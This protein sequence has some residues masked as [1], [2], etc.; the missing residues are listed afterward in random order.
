MNGGVVIKL[1]DLPPMNWKDTQLIY[2]A[3]ARKNE[4]CLILTSTKEP[5][6]CIGFAG[7]LKK[8]LDLEYCKQNDIG[9]FRRE[10]GGGTVYLDKDQLFFQ[11]ILRRD[12]P[13]TP[14]FQ[15]AFFKRFLEPVVKT[16]NS[17]GM[18]GRFV[19]LNDLI[20][21][22]KKISGN[23]GGEIGD[24]KV[25]IGNLLLDFDFETMVEILNVPNEGFRKMVFNGMQS[26]MT[27][28]KNEL[29][30]IPSQEEM[31]KSLVLEYEKLLGPM[32]RSEPED[33]VFDL[34]R[35]LEEQFSSEK[36]LFQRVPK[37]EGRDIKIRES[38][39]I[40][41]RT[42]IEKDWNVE[43]NLEL[44]EKKIMELE[45]VRASGYDVS[46][47]TLITSMFG[48]IFA[49]KEVLNTLKELY[50]TSK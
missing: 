16:L 5:Y 41:N 44:K 45:I 15:E 34:M 22:K 7:D 39:M 13:I 20:V 10:T 3:L 35:E 11:L 6:A 18:E 38:V 47:D 19:P 43:L 28:I 37:K 40:F 12:N 24:C 1:Y 21:N 25:L 33:D 2:H 48:K 50:E 42:Y 29:G 4:E 17:L 36:W 49:E 46:Y 27:T 32:E 8:E 23:G 26:N 30:E 14:R 9:Y 31:R